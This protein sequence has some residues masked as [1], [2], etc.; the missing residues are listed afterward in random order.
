MGRSNRR[1]TGFVVARDVE[2]PGDW[3]LKPISDLMDEAPLF[4]APMLELF[5]FIARYYRSSLGDAIRA[6]LP[7]AFNLTESRRAELTAVGREHLSSSPILSA[8]ALGPKPVR[9]LECSVATLLRMERDGLVHLKYELERPKATS[10]Q[11]NVVNLLDGASPAGLK[12]G[13]APQQLFSILES[14]GAQQVPSLKGR[15]KNHTAAVKRLVSIGA[16]TIT[17]TEVFRDPWRGEAA[18]RDTPPQLTDEQSSAV[19]SLTST[20]DSNLYQGFLLRGVTGSGKTEVYLHALEHALKQGGGGIVLVPEIALTPQ[21]AGRFRA[22]FGDQVAVLHSGLTNGERLDQWELIRRGLRPVVVGA[23]SALFAPLPDVRLIV[24]D[25]EHEGS[26]KQDDTPRYHGRDLALK[27]GQ[28]EKCAVVLGSATPSLETVLNAERGRLQRIDLPNRIAKRP[29]PAAELVDLKSTPPVRQ[30]ALLSQR[31][32]DALE[33]TVRRREQAIVFINRRGYSNFLLCQ[34]CGDAVQCPD[35]SVSLTY[36][37]SRRRLTC[38]YCGLQ[39]GIPTSCPS[40]GADALDQIGTGTE[41]VEQVIAEVIPG[42][43]VA[44]MDRDTTRGRALIRLLD[45][46]R[47]REIDILV[48]TQMV[49]K[50]HDFPAVTLVGVL[51]AEQM[52]H[53]QD[54]RASER[55]FQLL[56]QVAG[57][58]GRHELPGRVLVQAYDPDHYSLQRALEHDFDGFVEQER[59]NRERRGFPPFVHLVWCRIDAIK[60]EQARSA[61]ERITKHVRETIERA[62]LPVTYTG[63][64]PAPIEKLK[65]RTRFVLQLKSRYRGA[66]H[67]VLLELDPRDHKLVGPARLAIDVDPINLM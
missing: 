57:R 11:V 1:L 43:R 17:R 18:I 2:V 14:E 33:E 15:I 7:A 6:G 10:K 56:T 36:H 31:L 12:S 39:V 28:L 38:H 24:V 60:P 48:G 20:I 22:R 50:G 13:A 29:L 41:Q 27:R 55:T 26:F 37:R 44:R 35:C 21:L 4:T 62:Q 5:E 9:S 34:T 52:L 25:E 40:C 61:A 19:E 47:A 49:A 51:L 42:A 46:F 64:M 23:R 67:K 58:A 59:R 53:M 3:K 66:L 65:G 32:I 16:A 30:E 8:L 63:P 45:R 54:F